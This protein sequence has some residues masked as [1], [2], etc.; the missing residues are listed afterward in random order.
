MSELTPLERRDLAA[1]EARE[2]LCTGP[3]WD[4]EA[5]DEQT[6]ILHVAGDPENAILWCDRCPA[7]RKSGKRCGWPKAADADFI[8]HARQDVRHLLA[9]VRRLAG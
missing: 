6:L 9:I 5:A 8:K 4:W 1:I 2:A 3:A 7:C